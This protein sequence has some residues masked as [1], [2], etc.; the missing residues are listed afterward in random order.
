MQ[1]KAT[2][3]ESYLEGLPEGRKE[4]IAR[5]REVIRM[6]LPKGFEECMQQGMLAYVVPHGLYPP[7]YHCNP[8]QP[9]PFISIASQKSHIA[10][11][12]MGLYGGL[13]MDWWLEA[14][15]RHS[16]N[17]PD[18]GKGCLR[19]KKPEDVPL[20]LIGELCTKLTPSAWIAH[21]EATIRR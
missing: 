13:L 12:H 18:L 16:D 2:S 1:S 6:N 7:G 14:W 5:L 8:K 17:K 9:V 20:Q 3:P 4:I 15:S 19:F 21:Y 10:V 11:Y